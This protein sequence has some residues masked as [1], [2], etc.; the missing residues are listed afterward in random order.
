MAILPCTLLERVAPAAPA[1]FQL[2]PV[3]LGDKLSAPAL[4]LRAILSLP[5]LPPLLKHP[6]PR[7]R[8]WRTGWQPLPRPPPIK[9]LP[10]TCVPTGR[11]E[12]EIALVGTNF[13][14]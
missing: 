8:R 7:S 2:A 5:P 14:R 6:L 13:E 4:G 12:R 1:R 10:R 3:F 11:N 9:V